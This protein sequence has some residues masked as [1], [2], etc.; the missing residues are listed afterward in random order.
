[1]INIL[2]HVLLI[3]VG[4]TALMDLWA[5]A[6][7][8]WFD[9]PSLD[10]RL[11]GRWIGHFPSGT[12]SHPSIMT[13]APKK[14]EA[15][16]GWTAHYAIGIIFA[17]A[18]PVAWGTGWLQSPTLF[19]ALLVGAV[20][21]SAPFLIMQPAFGF[22]VAASKTPTPWTTR[23]RSLSAHGAFGVGLYLSA[24]ILALVA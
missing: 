17:A 5:L 15:L 2:L 9:I 19:P 24:K 12:F 23:G 8:R 20:S 21:V 6:R 13:A 14:Q 18:L 4:A 22:G 10:Y 11:V 3:G 1:M 7:K 16:V